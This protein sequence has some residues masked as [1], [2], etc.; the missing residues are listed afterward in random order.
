MLC[1]SHDHG[2]ASWIAV[3]LRHFPSLGISKLYYTV[4]VLL[5]GLRAF[6]HDCC[7]RQCRG[8]TLM[9]NSSN[10]STYSERGRPYQMNSCVMTRL[11]VKLIGVIKYINSRHRC[12]FK[13]LSMTVMQ[14]FKLETSLL[15]WEVLKRNFAPYVLAV[16]SPKVVYFYL[17]LHFMSPVWVGCMYVRIAER[18]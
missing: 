18:L 2:P 16:K 1:L 14:Y 3:S 10:K 17:C 4:C 12:P 13:V 8:I 7:S 15:L 9:G 6:L 11:V 5:Y